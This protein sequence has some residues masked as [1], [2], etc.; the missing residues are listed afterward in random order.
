MHRHR[1][2]QGCRIISGQV[3]SDEHPTTCR[4]SL[5]YEKIFDSPFPVS[6]HPLLRAPPP[7]PSP[8][9]RATSI[10]MMKAGGWA[11][12]L[13]ILAYLPLPPIYPVAA[14]PAVS[15]ALLICLVGMPTWPL[16]NSWA[17]RAPPSAVP[18]I[19]T[20]GS[21]STDGIPYY[22][23]ILEGN[24]LQVGYNDGIPTTSVDHL[25]HPPYQHRL[26]Q[27]PQYF[28]RHRGDPHHQRRTPERP[29]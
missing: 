24:G 20:C 6:S 8:W 28:D 1:G 22:A 11:I 7:L 16:S 13:A 25:L 10:P 14:T 5:N 4:R 27:E 21:L 23:V 3:S 19:L 29:G 18:L 15:S 12:F 26:V 2:G 9:C 17:T